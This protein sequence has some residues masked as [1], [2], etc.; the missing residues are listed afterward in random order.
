MTTFWPPRKRRQIFPHRV[1]RYDT[2]HVRATEADPEQKSRLRFHDRIRPSPRR[3][4]RL[5]HPH[6]RE[7]RQPPFS[8]RPLPP[9]RR[10]RRLRTP[11]APDRPRKN[12]P[13]PPR[14]KFERATRNCR[15]GA[16]KSRIAECLLARRGRASPPDERFVRTRCRLAASI[17]R[18]D[19]RPG[20][21]IT[22]IRRGAR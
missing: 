2:K 8:R 16:G 11:P 22:R 18:R 4:K 12:P 17:T 7:K 14:H 1:L 21:A 20:S 19:R 10:F 6:E 3:T 5:V 13:R 9:T 15:P